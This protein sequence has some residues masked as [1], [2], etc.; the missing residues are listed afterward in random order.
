MTL[1]KAPTATNPVG[2]GGVAKL[3][4]A[5]TAV[6]AAVKLAP[7]PVYTITPLSFRSR[8]LT[9]LSL[10]SPLSPSRTSI[11]SLIAVRILLRV[12]SSKTGSEIAGFFIRPLLIHL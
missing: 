12:L 7:A 6:G 1:V 9:N 11:V 10:G 2:V 5:T 4:A 3:T 8:T